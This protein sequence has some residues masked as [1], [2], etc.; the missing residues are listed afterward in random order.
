MTMLDEKKEEVAEFA[1]LGLRRAFC[2]VSGEENGRI[3]IELVVRMPHKGISNVENQC[4][5]AKKLG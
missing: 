3:V 2:L 4:I 5:K 1:R